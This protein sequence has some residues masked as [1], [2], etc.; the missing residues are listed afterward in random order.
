MKNIPTERAISQGRTHAQPWDPLRYACPLD[1]PAPHPFKRFGSIAGR[2]IL[3][4]A[5]L[6][7]ITFIGRHV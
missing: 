1:R 2:F 5:V 6:A 7:A 4:A 3:A